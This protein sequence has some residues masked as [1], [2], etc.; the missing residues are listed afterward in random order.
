[1]TQPAEAA[2]PVPVNSF[3]EE[4]KVQLRQSAAKEH[5]SRDALSYWQPGGRFGTE[6]ADA[7][8]QETQNSVMKVY[9][10][11]A[12]DHKRQYFTRPDD[13]IDRK[14]KVSA[15][16]ER[17]RTAPVVRCFVPST[18]II[19]RETNGS[20]CT[21]VVVSD[22]YMTWHYQVELQACHGLDLLSVRTPHKLIF[23]RSD[24]T[25]GIG[26]L[27]QRPVT[28]VSVHIRT[29]TCHKR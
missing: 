25:F 21:C 12:G 6:D 29:F 4:L 1:M 22:L 10:E 15:R 3:V 14:L 11:Q 18:E 28:A 8:M 20:T 5:A 7:Q 27:S 9:V 19:W 16:A 24:T 17:V 26:V 2:D 23:S 13:E